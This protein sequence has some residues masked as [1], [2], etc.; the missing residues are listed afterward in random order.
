MIAVI[1]VPFGRLS[2]ASTAAC[3]DLRVLAWTIGFACFT[4]DDRLFDPDRGFAV[5]GVFLLAIS[6][7]LWSRRTIA[8]HHRNPAEAGRR[9]RGE[10]LAQSGRASVEHTDALFAHEVERKVSNPLAHVSSARSCRDR[11]KLGTEA[12][13]LCCA[14]VDAIQRRS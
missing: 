11:T 1:V 3:L 5:T 4:F 13:S 2:N 12:L 6:R 9:W 14:Q 7:L 10:E 8:L